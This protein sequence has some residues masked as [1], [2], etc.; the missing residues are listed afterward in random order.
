MYVFGLSALIAILFA[1]WDSFST[2]FFESQQRVRL[3]AGI[4]LNVIGVIIL[5]YVAHKF[6][7]W[8][9]SGLILTLNIVGNIALGALYFGDKLSPMQYVW[10]AFGIVGIM[11]LSYY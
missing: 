9:S 10:L 11:I 1:L 6:G 2:K 5:G 8:S 3:T 7:L 4:W